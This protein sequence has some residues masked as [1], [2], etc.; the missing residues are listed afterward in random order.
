MND[1]W[2]VSRQ[3]KAMFFCWFVGAAL[4]AGHSSV[5]GRA[6]ANNQSVRQDE[7]GQPVH[8]AAN[9]TTQFE[10]HPGVE[11]GLFAAE[12]M[13]ANPSN[14]DIDHLGRVWV[15]EVIN[16]R[17]FRNKDAESARAPAIGFL[18]SK[19]PMAMRWLTNPPCSTKATTLT[20]PTEYACWEIARSFPRTIPCFT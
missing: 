20:L 10:L 9:A 13:M 7:A 5:F 12:P 11:V 8:Q 16:Y 4:I 2:F 3:K 14:I 6:I 1:W 17:H 19:T 18:F 15:C